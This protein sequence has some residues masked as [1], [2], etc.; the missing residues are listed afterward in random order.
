MTP[1]FLFPVAMG[2]NQQQWQKDDHPDQQHNDNWFMLP[3][4]FDEAGDVFVHSL[5]I[6][7]D[8]GCCQIASN[9]RGA[10]AAAAGFKPGQE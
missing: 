9:G 5:I 6:Y 3:D 1:L 2:V 8:S 7:T 10:F 4:V